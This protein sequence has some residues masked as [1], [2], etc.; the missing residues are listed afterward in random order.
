MITFT[1]IY[2]ALNA[3]LALGTHVSRSTFERRS[4]PELLGYFVLFLL[5]GLPITFGVV[6]FCL[7]RLKRTEA[8]PIRHTAVPQ[9]RIA[10]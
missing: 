2:F 7:A 6:I 4:A 3:V 10:R 1:A 9:L 5:F 8:R